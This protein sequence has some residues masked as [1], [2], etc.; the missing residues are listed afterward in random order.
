[1]KKILSSTIRESQIDP[2]GQVPEEAPVE[3]PA[4]S[5]G[6]TS[7]GFH[8]NDFAKKLQ[9]FDQMVKDHDMTY[10]LTDDFSTYQ[11]GAGERKAI[12][13]LAKDIPGESA[14]RIWNGY[15]DQKIKMPD[16]RQQF[17]W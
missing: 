8:D 6:D 15:V 17:Y 4:E 7:G 3:V 2:M 10:L 14:A 12:T 11:K 5:Q 13:E 16:S 1:M 9:D